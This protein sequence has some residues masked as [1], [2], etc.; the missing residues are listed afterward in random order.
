[1]WGSGGIAPTFLTSALDG[2]MWSTSR[3]CHFTHRDRAPGTHWVGGCMIDSTWTATLYPNS[4][5]AHRLSHDRFL[6]NPF[7][8]MVHRTSIHYSLDTDNVV[9]YHTYNWMIPKFMEAETQQVITLVM[10]SYGGESLRSRQ[11]LSYSRISEHFIEHLGTLTCSQE[12]SI[13][14]CP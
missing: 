1:M 12:S 2:G 7:Q 13:G 9:K 8:W 11:S 4:A 10:L 5:M 3:L 14:L 6:A